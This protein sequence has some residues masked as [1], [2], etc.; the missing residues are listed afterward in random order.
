[1]D[2]EVALKGPE[3]M[4]KFL[5][6]ND[7]LPFKKDGPANALDYLNDVEKLERV[8][9]LDSATKTIK[10]GQSNFYKTPDQIMG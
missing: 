10:S 3:G 9:E 7:Y 1:M 5:K 4:I 6:D 2:G 8:K